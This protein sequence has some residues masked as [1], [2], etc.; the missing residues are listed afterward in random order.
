MLTLRAAD[1]T[2]RTEAISAMGSADMIIEL[3]SGRLQAVVEFKVAEARSGKRIKT[4]AASVIRQEQVVKLARDALQQIRTL[5][6]M[7]GAKVGIPIKFVGVVFNS[8]ARTVAE[9]GVS[10]EDP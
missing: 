4:A 8:E 7:A 9:G 3:C 5:N 6:Y 2:V 10:I 1:V